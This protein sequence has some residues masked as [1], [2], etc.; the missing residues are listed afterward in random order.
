M[1]NI[2]L[3]I[4]GKKSINY[5]SYLFYKYSFNLQLKL[6]FIKQLYIYSL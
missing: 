3:T 4:V 2:N 5:D 1:N 6:W